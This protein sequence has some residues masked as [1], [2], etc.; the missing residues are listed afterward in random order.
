MNRFSVDARARR[1]M[2]GRAKKILRE[3]VAAW[4]RWAGAV[5]GPPGSG[6]TTFLRALYS[7]ARAEGLGVCS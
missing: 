2:G 4:P 7:V 3:L 6:K 5:C 1:A